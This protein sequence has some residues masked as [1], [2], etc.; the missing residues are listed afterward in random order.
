M[1]T[2]VD[3][4]EYP[5]EQTFR[6]A[7]RERHS[8]KTLEPEELRKRF[9]GLWEKVWGDR[10]RKKDYWRGPNKAAPFAR[11][12]YMFLLK[13]RVLH[14]YEPYT[15]Q[16]DRGQ[17]TGENAVVIWDKYRKGEVPM[18]LGTTLRRPRFVKTPNYSVLAQWLAA[19][20]YAETVELGIAQLPL[21]YGE[22]WTTKSVDETLALRWISG[23][24]S[25]A[26]NR[27]DF[28]RI[29]IQCETCSRPCKEVFPRPDDQDW[30]DG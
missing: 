16:L 27:T 13:Y 22:K 8:G 14:P 2:F 24:V 5:A 29:G 18:V 19:R 6:W 25:E 11:R 15:L 1:P 26:A 20:R 9:V 30:I 12:V 17:V 10:E 3:P 28:P 4:P 7:V 23:I 21:I